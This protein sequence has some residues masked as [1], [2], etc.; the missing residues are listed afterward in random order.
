LSLPHPFGSRLSRRRLLAAGGTAAAGLLS[1]GCIARQTAAAR[2]RERRITVWHPWGGVMVP[3]FQKIMAAFRAAH[4]DIRVEAVYTQNNLSTNQKFF[5][6]IA[7]GTPPD[8]TFV[9]GPQVASWAEWGALEPLTERAEASGVREEEYFPPTWRQCRYKDQTWAL[10]YSADPNFGFAWNRTAF[11]KA[12]LDPDRPPTTIQELTETAE[13]LTRAEDGVVKQIGLMPWS[14]YGQA[15]SIFTWGWAFGGEFYD[16]A[17]QKIT[18]DHPRVVKALEWM[19]EPAKKYDPA[20]LASIDKEIGSADANP[21]YSGRLAMRCLHI[22][23]IRDIERYAPDLNYDI[24]YLPAPEDGEAHSAWVGGWCM[25]IPKGAPNPDDAWELIRWLCHTPEGTGTVGQEAGLFPGFRPSPYFEAVR[26]KK[27]YADYARIL[28]ESRH[29]RPVMPVQAFYMREL[30][31][32]V[33]AAVYGRATPAEA[34]ARA[35]ENTQAELDLALAG[36]RS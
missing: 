3:R 17:A 33:D 13:R 14:Q 5:T 6:A 27:Y 35:R 16:P 34:L 36:S 15:N 24:T 20:R 31:R 25:G 23:G 4:P 28:S 8:V 18:A 7:A 1:G 32:A 21:F 26:G 11:R 9:D 19:I 22:G 12:G 10:T 30:L 2:R 29:Q